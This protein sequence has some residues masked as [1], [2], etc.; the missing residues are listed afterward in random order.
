VSLNGR[1][2]KLTNCGDD[3]GLSDILIVLHVSIKGDAFIFIKA[4]GFPD[5]IYKTLFMYTIVIS[6]R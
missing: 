3:R 6:I 5:K 2:T 4:L 1:N